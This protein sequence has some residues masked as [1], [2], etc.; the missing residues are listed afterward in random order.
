[1]PSMTVAFA[2]RGQSLLVVNMN[3]LP[4]SADILFLQLLG[5]GLFH[6]I[7]EITCNLLVMLQ[8][9]VPGT[10][11]KTCNLRVSGVHIGILPNRK[12]AEALDRADLGGTGLELQGG[13][14]R[15]WWSGKRRARGRDRPGG[16]RR[17]NICSPCRTGS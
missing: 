16:F 2:R 3:F 8:K 15:S 13:R 5:Y 10:T 17:L 1:L 7:C 9:R 4:L 6:L 11:S 12:A 14:A